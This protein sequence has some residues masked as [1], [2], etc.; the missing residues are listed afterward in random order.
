LTQ[1]GA[2]LEKPGET[3]NVSCKASRYTFTSYGMNWVR[4][5]AGK[6]LQYMGWINTESGKPS[7]YEGF[8]ELFVFSMDTSVSTAYLL[9]NIL[10]SEDTAMYYCARDNVK[11]TS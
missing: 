1:S 10:K 9:I 4:Q 7:Y 5:E 3:V 6:G 2:E 11:T 8:T